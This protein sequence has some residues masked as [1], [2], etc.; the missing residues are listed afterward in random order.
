MGDKVKPLIVIP[1]FNGKEFLPNLLASIP[2]DK[3]RVLVVDTGSTDPDSV[4]LLNNIDVLVDKTDVAGFGLGGYI[5]AYDKYPSD[6][7]FFM[8]DSMVVKDPDFIEKFREKGDVVGWLKFPF[9]E[10]H[11][12]YINYLTA[13]YGDY[14]DA[15]EFGIFGPIFYAKKEALDA[16]RELG[17]F[18]EYPTDKQHLC[19]QERG[20]AI[21]FKRAGYDMKFIETYDYE[22]LDNRRDYE[23][24][25]KIRPHRT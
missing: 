10:Q 22:R 18:K 20:M 1:Y 24:F 5:L 23:L 25:D 21:A 12:D 4:E 3:Y 19:A 14:S 16:V 17:Y 6:E 2:K 7:Y 13:D 8:H 11:D 15:P 9:S